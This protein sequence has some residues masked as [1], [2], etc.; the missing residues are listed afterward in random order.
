MQPEGREALSPADL[1]KALASTDLISILGKSQVRL[2][3]EE[4]AAESILPIS[5]PM[6]RR[7]GVDGLASPVGFSKIHLSLSRVEEA[8]PGKRPLQIPLAP[9]WV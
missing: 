3:W 4:D 8:R 2:L 9:W 6:D 5:D 7:K 1:R